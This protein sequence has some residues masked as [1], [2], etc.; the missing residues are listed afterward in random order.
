MSM[1]FKLVRLTFD[2]REQSSKAE[3]LYSNF[4]HFQHQAS[5][6]GFSGMFRTS[7]ETEATL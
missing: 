3:L 4:C 1:S 6:S 7:G 5:A 2:N